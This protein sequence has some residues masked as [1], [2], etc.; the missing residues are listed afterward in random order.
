MPLT[1]LAHQDHLG[2]FAGTQ[3][4][5]A[6]Q[7]HGGLLLEVLVLTLAH[8]VGNAVDHQ[9]ALFEGGLGGRVL[10]GLVQPTQGRVGAAGRND[11]QG[12]GLAQFLGQRRVTVGSKHRADKREQGGEGQ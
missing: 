11:D 10:E 7:G 4:Q 5:L 2:A 1:I 3:L 8:H 9:V 12:P 6:D